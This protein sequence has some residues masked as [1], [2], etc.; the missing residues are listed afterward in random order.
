MELT[1]VILASVFLHVVACLTVDVAFAGGLTIGI[2][3]YRPCGYL[4][5][6]LPVGSE[7]FLNTDTYESFGGPLP[8]SV[9]MV[10]YGIEAQDLPSLIPA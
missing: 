5:L 10:D 7:I 1:F 8:R 2:V 3:R 4:D 6:P 9:T